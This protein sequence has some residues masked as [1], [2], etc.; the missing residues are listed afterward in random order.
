MPKILICNIHN[1][2]LQNKY[3]TWY[4]KKLYAEKPSIRVLLET[5]GRSPADDPDFVPPEGASVSFSESTPEGCLEIEERESKAFFEL[6]SEL[7]KT[8]GKNIMGLKDTSA[9]APDEHLNLDSFEAF[10]ASAEGEHDAAMLGFIKQEKTDFVAV[11]GMLHVAN[12]LFTHKIS[13]DEYQIIF[14]VHSETLTNILA[15]SAEIS[16]EPLPVSREI[17]QGLFDAVLSIDG[18]TV[19]DVTGFEGSDFEVAIGGAVVEASVA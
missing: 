3:T 12:W 19:K 6:T 1:D 18:M 14:P 11:V 13:S 7:T 5:V 8:M 16:N 17:A 10:L 9:V 4:I 2:E 15:Y